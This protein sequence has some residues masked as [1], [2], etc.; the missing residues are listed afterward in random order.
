MR[1]EVE[2]ERELLLGMTGFSVDEGKML[3]QLGWCISSSLLLSA[4]KESDA[5]VGLYDE[6]RN[7]QGRTP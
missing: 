7:G 2:P 5:S 3:A 6:V 1:H 4:L